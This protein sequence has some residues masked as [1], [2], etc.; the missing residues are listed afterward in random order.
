MIYPDEIELS[1]FEV[2]HIGDHGAFIH[3]TNTDLVELARRRIGERRL[4][5]VSFA[6]TRDSGIEARRAAT[7]KSDAVEDESHGAR[8]AIAQINPQ[9]KLRAVK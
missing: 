1:P 3:R 6:V 8:S 9:P 7:P 5:E 2:R 4:A